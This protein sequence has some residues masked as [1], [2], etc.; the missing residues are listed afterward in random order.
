MMLCFNKKKAWFLMKF[1]LSHQN[2][3]AKR[4]Q[5]NNYLL[6]FQLLAPSLGQ[7]WEW[8]GA[9]REVVWLFSLLQKDVH[10]INVSFVTSWNPFAYLPPLMNFKI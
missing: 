5:Q 9:P 3:Q 4:K 7:R 2:K 8:V 1:S 10:C 6:S